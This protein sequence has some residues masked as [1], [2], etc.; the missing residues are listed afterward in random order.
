MSTK[1]DLQFSR[2]FS[3]LE[4]MLGETNSYH[5][6][7]E[8]MANA[9][10]VAQLGIVASIFSMQSLPSWVKPIPWCNHNISPKYLIYIAFI[11]LWL[12]IHIFIRWQLRN[13]RWAAIF[14]AAIEETLKNWTYSNPR[15]ID[16]KPYQEDTLK[17]KTKKEFIDKYIWPL[18]SAP[19]YS[20]VGVKGW[21]IGLMQ[22][23]DK[24]RD[25]FIRKDDD[26]IHP[27]WLLS[28]GSIFALIVGL[29][30][31][32]YLPLAS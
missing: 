26:S 27:E 7:K 28:F 4:T 5:H 19:L 32:C 16:L 14:T 13:R 31:I 25:A 12:L 22:E 8:T 2:G 18:R 21:P 1:K 20:D 29:V 23:L 24:K 9:G 3:F 10:I 30:S 11:M 15:P 6:H 17:P